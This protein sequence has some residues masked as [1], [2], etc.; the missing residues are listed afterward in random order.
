MLDGP[1][2]EPS[3]E[4]QWWEQ[5]GPD[6]LSSSGDAGALQDK[7]TIQS[8]LKA[9]VPEGLNGSDQHGK[10]RMLVP[11]ILIWHVC[12]LFCLFILKG[13]CGCS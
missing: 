5:L 3:L 10:L 2:R 7:M 4:R 8:P 11:Y 9:S 12:G 1:G 6:E 13:L